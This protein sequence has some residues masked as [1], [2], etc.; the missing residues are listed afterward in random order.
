MY[1]DIQMYMD[2]FNNTGSTM[3][4][5]FRT[6]KYIAYLKYI[7]MASISDLDLIICL[8][9]VF[10]GVPLFYVRILVILLCSC[11]INRKL[12][13]TICYNNTCFS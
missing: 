13:F 3:F 5:V 12:K 9:L 6:L 10:L 1:K 8:P 4:T 2:S 7:L 11:T